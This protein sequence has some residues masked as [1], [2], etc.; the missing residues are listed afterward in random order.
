MPGSLADTRRWMRHGTTLFLQAAEL[1]D[2]ALAQRSAL[3]GWS[4]KHVIAHV[5][6]NADALGN[7]IHWAATG[8]P[9]PMYSSPGE[10]AAGIEHGSL[11]PA[12]DLQAWLRRSAGALEDASS[13]LGTDHWQAPVVTAQGRTVPASEVPWLRAREVYVHAVDLAVDLS[14]ADLPADFMATLCDDMITKRSAGPGPAVLLEAADTHT[15]WE[16][17][18]NGKPVAVSGPLGDLTAY[19]AGRAHGLAAGGG[20]PVPALPPW[21]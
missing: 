5:A 16:L 10:R 18:G 4:R 14:F 12:A 17:P 6:A 11:L 7:L 21:L 9:T 8:Q 1:N 2:H 13:R 20:G 15:R 19:L 3:P